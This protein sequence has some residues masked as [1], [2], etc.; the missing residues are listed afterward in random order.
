MLLF[1]LATMLLMIPILGFAQIILPG[2]IDASID[3]AALIGQLIANPKAFISISGGALL[4]YLAVQ[5]LKSEYCK[6]IFKKLSDKQQFAIITIL[7]Q[8]Y[9]FVVLAFI[10]KD[11][12]ISKVIVGVFSSGGAAAIFGAF[13]LLIE[14]PKP[15]LL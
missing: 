2:T 12:E 4:V 8:V 15:T 11:Q 5:F 10:T 3:Y 9:A 6:K 13:K 7:G 1:I 14:K